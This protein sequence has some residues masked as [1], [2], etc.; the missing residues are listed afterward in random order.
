LGYGQIWDR[1]RHGIWLICF[2][3]RG[4]IGFVWYF[5]FR[6]CFG[7]PLGAVEPETL[8]FLDGAVGGGLFVGCHWETPFDTEVAWRRA[9]SGEWEGEV[10]WNEGKK[11]EKKL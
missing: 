4:E 9:V 5:C 3:V 10:V 11:V 7:F 1:L 8:E 6:H 2:G